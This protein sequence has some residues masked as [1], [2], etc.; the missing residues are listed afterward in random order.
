MFVLLLGGTVGVYSFPAALELSIIHFLKRLYLYTSL[1]SDQSDVSS[2][3]AARYWCG[4]RTPCVG[5]SHDT[6]ESL[7]YTLS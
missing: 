1:L 5:C 4:L 2:K 6:L 3:I 7:V